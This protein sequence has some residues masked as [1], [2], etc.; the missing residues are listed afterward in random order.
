[1]KKNWKYEIAR[2]SMAFGSILFY[3]IVIVRSLIGEYL[4]FVYQLLI[5][6]AVLIISYFIV[7][8]TNHHIARAFVIL[9]FTSL[10]YKDNFF[11]FFAALLW[12]FMIGAAFYMKENKKSIFKGI[13]LGT[14]AALVGYYLSLV[15]G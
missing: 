7:K 1:M 12:I 11:T 2:D 14:V 6:L 13:V 9:I 15:V 4:V 8:N 5:S 3:L 10:F